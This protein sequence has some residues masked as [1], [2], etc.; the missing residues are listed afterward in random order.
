[1]SLLY[2]NIKATLK[3]RGGNDPYGQ[4]KLGR[5]RA[6]KVAVVKSTFVSQHTTV[7]ADSSGTRGYAHEFV[8]NYRFLVN[9]PTVIDIDD[10]LTVNGVVMRVVGKIPRYDLWGKVDHYE[11]Q[12]ALWA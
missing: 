3:K 7:R 8:A 5:A 9:H 12:G 6:L 2:C 1:M 10:Q 11:L 4:E